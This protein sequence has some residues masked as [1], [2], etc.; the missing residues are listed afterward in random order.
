MNEMNGDNNTLSYIFSK[1]MKEQAQLLREARKESSK[2]KKIKLTKEQYAYVYTFF[3]RHIAL[4]IGLLILLFSQGVIES[5]LVVMSRNELSETSRLWFAHNLS[6]IFS[7]G[8][9][10]FL[11]NS[12]F[13]I[14]YERS[15]VVMLTNSI[16]RRLFK[17]YIE[18]AYESTSR[19]RQADSIAKLSYHL[20][21]ASLGVTNTLFGMWKWVVYLGTVAI[22]AYVGNY[23]LL[24]IMMLMLAVSMIV[25]IGA[26]LVSR[27]YVSQEV[28]FYSKIIREVDFNASDINFLKIFGQE[29]NIISK[30]DRLVW[31]DSFFRVRRDILMRIGFKVVFVMLIIVSVVSHFFPS[32]FSTLVGSVSNGERFL[33]LFLL[34]YFGRALNEAAKV[35]L[36]MFPARLGLFLTILKPSNILLKKGPYE[37]R[38]KSITFYSHK[39]K[40]FKEGS[41][42]RRLQII[43]HPGDRVLF[44]GDNLSGK[45]SLARSMAGITTYNPRAFKI[46]IDQERLEFSAWQKLC[47]DVYFFDPNFRSERSILE[48]IL[49]VIKEQIAM[50]DIEHTLAIINQYPEITRLVATSGNYNSAADAVLSNQLPAFAL[51]T[52]HCLVVQPSLIII[53]N[54]W[55]DL[56]YPDI[57]AMLKILEKTL[58]QSII[59]VYAR[60]MNR[61][62]AYTRTYEIDKKIK[63]TT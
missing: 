46:M 3:R 47:S 50:E 62:I 12:F 53:D 40:F 15:L 27:L 8:I 45:T 23:H 44:F 9:T 7:V 60:E 59:V 20:P 33:L 32:T 38:G 17:N 51:H 55:T 18:Q 30:F 63:H 29:S 10:V 14:K 21:L 52:L 58:P 57:S 49:G 1:K 11:L 34:I 42:H 54:L 56:K 2:W 13:S 41:Y 31:F 36:Y 22:I 25:C 4:V 48:C 19:E 5:L 28:T 43:C 61:D 37:I 26:Y 35:G 24:I 16:R 39:T 6:I